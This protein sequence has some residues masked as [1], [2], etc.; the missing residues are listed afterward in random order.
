MATRKGKQG[1]G[2]RLKTADEVRAEF[3]RAGRT[4]AD[5]ARERGLDYHTAHQVLSGA[6]KGRRGEAHRC[7]VA[8]G[9]K[10]G[11]LA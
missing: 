8:L 4:L 5:F 2:A 10:H 3:D 11:E 1:N 9:L 6:K 7:A